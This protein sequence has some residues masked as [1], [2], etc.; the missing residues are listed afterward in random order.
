VEEASNWRILR[1]HVGTRPTE[2]VARCLHRD[3]ERQLSHSSC[4]AGHP[5][6]LSRGAATAAAW[7]PRGQFLSLCVQ[8]PRW[9]ARA[10]PPH[11]GNHRTSASQ[12]GVTRASPATGP[13]QHGL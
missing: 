10:A 11:R 6:S 8:A 5:L 7:M 2:S 13:S 9:S 12:S 1:K 3:H 4:A